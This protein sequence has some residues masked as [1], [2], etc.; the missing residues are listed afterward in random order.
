[1]D[2]EYVDKGI[3]IVNLGS[4]FIG[5]FVH[6]VGGREWCKGGGWGVLLFKPAASINLLEY[7][8][9]RCNL[10]EIIYRL[11]KHI[12]SQDFY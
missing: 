3:F 5:Q 10:Q 2:I 4:L 6:P 8:K 7:M 11:F 1:M 12:H 9:I